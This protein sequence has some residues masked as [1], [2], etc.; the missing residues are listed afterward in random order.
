MLFSFCKRPIVFFTLANT[1]S[2]WSWNVNLESNNTP[3]SFWEIFCEMSVLLKN[4]LR[5]DTLWS[6]LLN[7]TS[8][9]C[10]LGSAFR[11]IFH[12]NAQLLILFKSSLS[13]FAEALTSLTKEKRDVSSANRLTIKVK[14]SGKSFI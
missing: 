6:F 13:F 12:W 11:L 3:R 7:E 10:L 1:M 4:N 5:C 2:R 14:T 9:A 8:W